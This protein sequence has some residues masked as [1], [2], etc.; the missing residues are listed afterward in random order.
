MTAF[1]ILAVLLLLA[2]LAVL[3]RPLWRD[4]RAVAIG[5]GVVAA[6]STLLLYQL[7]GTPQA[8][9]PAAVTAP[10]TLGDAIAQ[11]E[12]EMQRNPKQAEGWRL[13]AQG[14]RAMPTPRLLSWRLAMPRSSPKPRSRARWPTTSACSIRK[15]LPCCNVH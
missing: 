4:A 5:V 7:V 12:T 6:T 15:P 2:V 3:L 14:Y 8:L 11:L 9:D 1:V 10:A 13:L